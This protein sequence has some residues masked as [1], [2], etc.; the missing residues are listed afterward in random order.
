MVTTQFGSKIGPAIHVAA[1]IIELASV[2]PVT[3][4]IS[5]FVILSTVL[6]ALVTRFRTVTIVAVPVLGAGHGVVRVVVNRRRRLC[7]RRR[8]LRRCPS[9]TPIVVSRP[10]PVLAV[11]L[12]L[13]SPLR[14]KVLAPIRPLLLL[15]AF[16]VVVVVLSAVLPNV[17][18]AVVDPL[19]TAMFVVPGRFI[20]N[21]T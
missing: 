9:R 3:L 12:V 6:P 7:N 21:D 10:S 4:P 5:V 19:L 20:D 2:F 1:L 16:S 17:W 15:P 14:F 13:V 11:V 8:N 18:T